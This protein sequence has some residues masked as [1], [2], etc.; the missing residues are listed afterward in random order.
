[1]DMSTRKPIAGRPIFVYIDLHL[2]VT[3]IAVPFQRGSVSSPLQ[4]PSQTAL[5]L[6][7]A[8]KKR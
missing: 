7:T 1:M 8:G 4:L 5:R 3:A 6:P 2:G